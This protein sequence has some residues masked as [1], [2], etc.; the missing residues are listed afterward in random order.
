MKFRNKP[1]VIE[2]FLWDPATLISEMPDWFFD[3][4]S[5]MKCFHEMNGTMSIFTLEGTMTVQIGDW[6]IRGVHG[7]LYPCKPS[8]FVA[9]YEVA[10]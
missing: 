3:A 2:A 1:V 9:T 10:E 8:V 6:I 5:D 4:C 7:E